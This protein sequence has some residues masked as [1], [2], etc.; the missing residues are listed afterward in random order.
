MSQFGGGSGA[1]PGQF[2]GPDDLA[3]DWAG[4]IYVADGSNNRV[5]VFTAD[6]QFVRQ[7]GTLGSGR[8]RAELSRTESRWTRPGTFTSPT[9][10]T[11]A[12]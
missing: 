2:S 3:V 7:F 4:N 10:A 8:W 11:P 9:A 6:G 1:G 12:S 5:Q